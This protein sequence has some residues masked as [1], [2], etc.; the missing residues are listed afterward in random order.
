MDID[1]MAKLKNETWDGSD[2]GLKKGQQ[3]NI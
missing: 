2:S 1:M 3:V